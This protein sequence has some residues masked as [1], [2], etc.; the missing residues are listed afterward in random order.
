MKEL[1]CIDLL[2]LALDLDSA[3]Y[4]IKGCGHVLQRGRGIG[5]VGM[6]LQNFLA[7][8]HAF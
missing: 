6:A 3:Y 7:A 5:K 1:N 4:A 2:A 8:T